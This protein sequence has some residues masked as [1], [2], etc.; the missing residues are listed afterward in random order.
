[1]QMCAARNMHNVRP[2]VCKMCGVKCAEPG[3]DELNTRLVG[4]KSRLGAWSSARSDTK[5]DTRS[6]G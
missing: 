6:S 1:M 4:A 3:S 5:S 2:R